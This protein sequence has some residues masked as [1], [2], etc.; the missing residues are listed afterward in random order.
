[1]RL[2]VDIPALHPNHR[3]SYVKQKIFTL[4]FGALCLSLA[5]AV[6]VWAQTS[7]SRISGTVTD[8]TGAVV[9]GAKVTAKNEATGVT[10]TQDDNQA[11]LYAFPS[12]PV[13][14]YTITVEWAGFKTA[15]ET[16]VIIQ[17]D[18]PSSRT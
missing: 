9:A 14:G 15:N 11:G 17:V 13:G 10:Y 3:R 2:T 7:T 16:G 5:L 4:L 12:L 6:C 1:M 18:T 8:S